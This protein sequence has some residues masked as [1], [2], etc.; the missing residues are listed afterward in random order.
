[1]YTMYTSVYTEV[2]VYITYIS[3]RKLN[4]IKFQLFI[5]DQCSHNGVIKI[6]GV[7]SRFTKIKT[8]LYGYVSTWF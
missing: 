1:M 5:S 4:S 2:I 8:K 6:Y 7:P 3:D